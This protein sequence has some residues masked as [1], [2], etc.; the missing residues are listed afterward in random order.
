MAEW[1]YFTTDVR[2][3]AVLAD[4]SASDAS[5]E[6]ALSGSGEGR[7]T[8]TVPA[9]LLDFKA[10]TEPVRC[11]L[12]AA[13][14]GVLMWGG[15]IWKREASGTRAVSISASEYGSY[16]DRRLVTR[17]ATFTQVD[18][19]DIARSLVTTAQ[20]VSGGDVRVVV[21]TETSGILRDRTYAGSDLASVASRLDELANVD[22]GF[23]YAWDPEYSNGLPRVRLSLGY[24]RLGSG[25][26]LIEAESDAVAFGW[27]EDGSVMALTAY[28]VGQVA[29]GAATGTAKP[30]QSVANADLLT[31]YPLVERMESYDVSDPAVLGQHATADL[32]AYSA[33]VVA[34]TVTVPESL[35]LNIGIRVGDVVRL[36][37]SDPDVWPGTFDGSLRCVGLTYDASGGTVGLKLA[38]RVLY[39]G[40]IP[41]ESDLVDYLATLGRNVRALQTE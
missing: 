7:V 35:A 4:I 2:T 38:D 13:A 20:A 8:V 12:W 37:N 22:K 40:R 34:P 1:S 41:A 25:E 21:G 29:D 3:G 19:L 11:A 26:H 24:P 5:F 6:R 18:Q 32:A 17:N 33:P 14:D 16:F 23:D 10:A 30:I 28:A 36:R 9:G 27:P 31:Q 39:G 15:I